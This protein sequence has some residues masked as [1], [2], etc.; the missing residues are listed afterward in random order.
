M[1]DPLANSAERLFAAHAGKGVIRVAEGGVRTVEVMALLRIAA[2]V[3]AHPVMTA[4]SF[5][6]ARHHC[7]GAWFAMSVTQEACR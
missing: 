2:A 6:A 4:P 1:S 7:P 3:L 5:F